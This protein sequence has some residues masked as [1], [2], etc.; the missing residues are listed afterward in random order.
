MQGNSTNNTDVGGPGGGQVA[1]SDAYRFISHQAD[2]TSPITYDPCRP[3][4][5]V[6]RLQG[7]PPGGEQIICDAVL[8][9]SQATGLHFVYDGSTSEAPSRQRPPYQ[10]KTYGDRWAPVLIS[11]VTPSENPDFA[12]DV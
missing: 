11:W 1:A 8:R 6:I 10:P 7:G 2:G 12:A 5:Y 9:V 3:V 4:H